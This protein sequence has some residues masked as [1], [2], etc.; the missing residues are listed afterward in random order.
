MSGEERYDQYDQVLSAFQMEVWQF[1]AARFD[2]DPRARAMKF[3]EEAGELVGAVVRL[4]EGRGSRSD[5]QDE[6]GDV[7]VTLAALLAAVDVALVDA[8]YCRWAE[9]QGRWWP[10]V[11]VERRSTQEDS[12]KGGES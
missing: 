9:V 8:V 2:S 5:V 11:D 6:A 4:L 12:D 3:A 7:V 10:H 1:C